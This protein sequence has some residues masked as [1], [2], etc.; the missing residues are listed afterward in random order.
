[1]NNCQINKNNQISSNSKTQIPC[2]KFCAN[3]CSDC[4]YADWSYQ[5]RDKY[6]RIICRNSSVGGYVFPEDRYGCWHYK[7]ERS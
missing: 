1:M 7:Y 6:N 4:L 5:S 3:N 2:G